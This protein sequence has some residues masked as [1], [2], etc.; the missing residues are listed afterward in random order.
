MNM[1]YK[2]LLLMLLFA[3]GQVAVGQETYVPGHPLYTLKERIEQGDKG[4]LFEIA[5]FLNPKNS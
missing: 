2:L 1:S 4:A 3:I 5:P